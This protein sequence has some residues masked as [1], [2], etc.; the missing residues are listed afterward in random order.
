MTTSGAA[1]L[2]VLA[3]AATPHAQD[4]DG[5]LA[6]V[7]TND[8]ADN[9]IKV[10]DADTRTLL[11]TLPTAGR[12]GAG[13]NQG[14]VRQY[15]GELLA[16]VNNGSN[17]VA[18]FRR[19]GRLLRF[20]GLVTTTSAPVSIAFGND[21]MYVAGATTVDSFALRGSTVDRQDGT[22][23]LELPGGGVPPLGS[24]AQVGVVDRHQLIVT[25]K[26]DPNPGAVD[27]V[28]LR[29]GAVTSDA[30]TVVAG[31]DGTLAPFGFAVYRDG[32][33]VVTLAHSAN[34]G[35]FRDGAFTS[36]IDAGQQGPCWVVVVGKYVFTVNTGSRT[37]SRL[38]GTGN[39]IFID[40]PVAAS[41]TAGGSPTDVDASNGVLAVIDH[42]AG[43]SHV[44][45]FAYNQFGELTPRG[46][47]VALGV[48][49]PNGIAVLAPAVAP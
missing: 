7:M 10:F 25:L 23:A 19:D 32:S 1:V 13:Q 43:T 9:S 28:A 11:Q 26:D 44:S 15:N 2:L 45:F 22:V 12:G 21:H 35:L 47:P 30:P 40:A 16:A 33:A 18:L 24:T 36:V 34:V 29:D 41:V 6:V 4:R 20:A 31:P 8:S 5:T 38:V 39:N 27:V 46:E 17:S 37:I 42:G 14:G 49:D 48:A 3:T